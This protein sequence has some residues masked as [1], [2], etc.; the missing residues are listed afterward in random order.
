MYIQ[1]LKS[2]IHNGI[3][4]VSNMVETDCIIIDKEIMEAVDLVEGEQIHIINH[5]NGERIISNVKNGERG[6]KII[7]V[8][9]PAAQKINVSDKVIIIAYAM[10]DCLE[11][12]Y[13]SPKI[14]FPDSKN[15][16]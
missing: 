6:S 1:T 12:E 7:C 8:N 13:Y 4:T 2:K 15:N 11:S 10:M 3:I 9:G 16:F 5:R 14:I